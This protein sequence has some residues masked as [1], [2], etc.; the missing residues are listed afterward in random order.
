VDPGDTAAGSAG[1]IVAAQ[2][3]D[4]VNNGPGTLPRDANKG[5]E[6]GAG[7]E[8]KVNV[9]TAPWPVLAA[10]PMITDAA[11]NIVQPANTLLAKAIVY[12]R[13]VA[14]E[15]GQPHGPF[16]SLFE[17]LKVPG[18]QTSIH[19][20]N[21]MANAYEVDLDDTDGDFSPYNRNPAVNRKP[22]KPPETDT[23]DHVFSD[24]EG[25]FLALTRVSNLLT[26][27]SD[28]FTVYVLV[29]AWRNAGTDHPE[30]VGQRRVA[31]L[32]DRTSVRPLP[33]P[34]PN[35]PSTS[36]TPMNIVTMPNN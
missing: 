4:S 30:L 33:P 2:T 22:P 18:F 6:D 15:T 17:L 9:N 19:G 8:G 7:E 14:D 32:A 12:Y 10:V 36:H 3:P 24:F 5:R 13:D 27:R 20:A 29:Q 34:A 1:G 31:F 26:T 11:G 25:E 28:S 35:V 23:S 16:R 21:D